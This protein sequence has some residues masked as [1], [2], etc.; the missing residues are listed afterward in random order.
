MYPIETTEAERAGRRAR[1]QSI[2]VNLQNIGQI[3]SLKK[4]LEKKVFSVHFTQSFFFNKSNGKGIY[5][6]VIYRW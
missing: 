4:S 1:A 6:Y 5:F 3:L 2:D